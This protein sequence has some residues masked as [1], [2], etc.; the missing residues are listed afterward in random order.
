[1]VKLAAGRDMAPSEVTVLCG[2]ASSAVCSF[3]SHSVKD[4]KLPVSK[5]GI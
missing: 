3:Q 2:L 5:E 1:M 4:A